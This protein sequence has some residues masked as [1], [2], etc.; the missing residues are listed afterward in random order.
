M[1]KVFPWV[2]LLMYGK[3]SGKNNADNC[4]EKFFHT[5]KSCSG[6]LWVMIHAVTTLVDRFALIYMLCINYDSV[7]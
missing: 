5:N 6:A 7:F 4:R 1:A 2:L 3:S